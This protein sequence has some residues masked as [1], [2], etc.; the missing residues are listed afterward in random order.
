MEVIAERGIRIDAVA[1][2][3]VEEL[4]DVLGRFRPDGIDGLVHHAQAELGC[5]RTATVV[6]RRDGEDGRLLRLIH[7]LRG[8]DL[9]VQLLLDGRHL[10][11]FCA[12]KEFI[13]QHEGDA[14][15]EVGGVF[16]A[17]G[18]LYGE[19]R[20]GGDEGPMGVNLPPFGGDQQ[21]RGRFAGDD[22]NLGHI[23]RLIGLLV[24]DDIYPLARASVPSPSRSGHP[25]ISAVLDFAPLGGA[26]DDAHPERA[27]LAQ[28]KTNLGDAVCVGPGLHGYERPLA[29]VLPPG[30]LGQFDADQRFNRITLVVA[31]FDGDSGRLPRF[32][33]VAVRLDV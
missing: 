1:D 32:I 19:G 24:G 11:L 2:A 3:A 27:L 10:D 12:L 25:E 13:L 22:E 20:A 16:G 28:R 5:D 17:D 8:A 26:G 4:D 14:E 6:L 7:L 18:N 29:G 33:D 23:A 15:E 21:V 30:P 9:H 31:R